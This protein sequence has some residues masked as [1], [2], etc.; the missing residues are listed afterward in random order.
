[1]G[2]V[3]LAWPLV[4]AGFARSFVAVLWIYYA[5]FAIDV[6]LFIL[7]TIAAIRYSR[8]AGSGSF[9]TIPW[10]GKIAGSATPTP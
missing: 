2:L 1:V 10:L 4:A 5:A 7:W 9:F 8:A 6:A 3:A